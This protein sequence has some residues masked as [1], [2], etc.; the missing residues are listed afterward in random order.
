MQNQFAHGKSL[1]YAT[2]LFSAGMVN[3]SFYVMIE[4]DV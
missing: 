1:L 3:K 2:S 4:F